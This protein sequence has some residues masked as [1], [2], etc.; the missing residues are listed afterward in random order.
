MD[1][2]YLNKKTLCLKL[3]K[4]FKE[5]YRYTIICNEY[6]QRNSYKFWNNSFFQIKHLSVYFKY[7]NIL[8]SEYFVCD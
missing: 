5:M 3:K 7:L 2:I 8:L 1:W 6:K 4:Y